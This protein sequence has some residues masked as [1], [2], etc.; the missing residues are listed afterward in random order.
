MGSQRD[1]EKELEIIRSQ[2]ADGVLVPAEVVEYAKDENTALHDRF[3]WDDTAA[4]IAYRIE[5]ARHL[6]RVV[7]LQAHENVRQYVSLTVDRK[8]PAGGGYRRIDD[9]LL[10]KDWRE[11]MLD[12]ARREFEFFEMKYQ[13]L[14]ELAPLFKVAKRVL[15]SK[16]KAKQEL[17]P[18]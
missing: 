11:L 4:A 14:V 9:V 10:R 15:K 5:Q 6:I 2:N 13:A 17:V 12:E 16:A 3:E 18:A 1:I 7:V 8:D